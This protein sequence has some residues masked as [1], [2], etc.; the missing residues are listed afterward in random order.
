[1]LSLESFGVP[2]SSSSHRLCSSFWR[3]CTAAPSYPPATSSSPGIDFLLQLLNRDVYAGRPVSHHSSWWPSDLCEHNSLELAKEH[4]KLTVAISVFEAGK[5]CCG[6]RLD[7]TWPWPRALNHSRRC[8][9]QH[10]A[11]HC[12]R[13][14]LQHSTGKIIQLQWLGKSFT[15]SRS[16]CFGSVANGVTTYHQNWLWAHLDSIW[17]RNATNIYTVHACN[18]L[19]SCHMMC[20]Q[21]SGL[22]ISTI[23]SE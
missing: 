16:R 19:K 12:P 9:C 22:L 8:W 10:P 15:T 1:M 17:L 11:K 21:C 6:I 5:N 2:A 4:W 14:A 13:L 23:E 3:A 20:L 18:D 7:E